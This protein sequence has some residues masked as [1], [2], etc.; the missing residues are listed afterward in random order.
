MTAFHWLSSVQHI[1]GNHLGLVAQ[2]QR[3]KQLKVN[4]IF[5]PHPKAHFL[6]VHQGRGHLRLDLSVCCEQL[7]AL[8][9]ESGVTA[10][11]IPLISLFKHLLREL[12]PFKLGELK[13]PQPFHGCGKEVLVQIVCLV[14][15]N[16]AV[17]VS[18]VD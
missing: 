3:D 13:R 1:S 14:V 18:S 7:L 15:C 17:L 6:A 11:M 9:W 8:L 10:S 4:V 12:K 5:L 16:L 2:V